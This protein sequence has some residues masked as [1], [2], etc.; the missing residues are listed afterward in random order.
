[1]VKKERKESQEYKD[2]K[3]TLVHGDHLAHKV[4]EVVEEESSCRR[5]GVF[6]G[7][8]CFIVVMKSTHRQIGGLRHLGLEEGE[9]DWANMT[10]NTCMHEHTNRRCW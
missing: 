4:W 3:E 2:R 1:M 10:Y 9:G 5:R 6:F 8:I 7:L